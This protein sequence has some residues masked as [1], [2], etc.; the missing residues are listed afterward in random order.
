MLVPRASNMEGATPSWWC[1][2]LAAEVKVLVRSDGQIGDVHRRRSTH[3]EEHSI[4]YIIRTDHDVSENRLNR[5]EHLVGQSLTGV[6]L[7]VDTGE[8]HDPG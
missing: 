8:R 5:I 2:E 1:G 3:R 6:D 4:S 7:D